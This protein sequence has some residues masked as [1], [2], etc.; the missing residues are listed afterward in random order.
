MAP[1]LEGMQRGEITEHNIYGLLSRSTKDAHNRAVL[2]G[3]AADELRHYNALKE[4]TGKEF[5]PDTMKI[6]KYVFLGRAL[7]LAFALKLMESGEESAQESYARLAKGHPEL[8]RIIGDEEAHEK[9]LIDMI[10]EERLDYASAI[11]LGLNDAL[12]ELTGALAGLTLAL[13]ESRLIAVSGLIIG[14]AAALS[15]AA[16]SYLSSREEQGRNPQKSALYTGTTYMATV[17]LLLLPYFL[18]DNVYASLA[19]MFAIALAL[20]ACYT[21]YISTAKSQRFLPRFA[22]MAAISLT[23]AA[24]SFAIGYFARIL[25]GLGA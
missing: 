11:V 22:E 18:L 4:V 24:I 25:F 9:K 17:F 19:A 2:A 21:F 16:S 3:I 14:V 15:M 8:R 1:T 13:Q 7:G 6:R 12:V 5:Q 20:V 10:K 23:V